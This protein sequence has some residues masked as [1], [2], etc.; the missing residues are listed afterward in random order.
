VA[1][2]DDLRRA[3]HELTERGHPLFSPAELVDEALRAGSRYPASTLRPHVVYWMC[4]NAPVNRGTGRGEF[5]RVARALYKLR[6][7][8]VTAGHDLSLANEEALP[9]RSTIATSQP[10][11]SVDTSVDPTALVTSDPTDW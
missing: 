3:A 11:S 5:V 9:P 6:D 7:S 4:A 1:A 8:D 10:A 2:K